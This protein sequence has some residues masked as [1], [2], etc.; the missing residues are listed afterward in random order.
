MPAAVVNERA[1]AVSRQLYPQF[2][3]GYPS[4]SF[5]FLK[6]L[7]KKPRPVQQHV[8]QARLPLRIVIVGA[9]LG[10]LAT[11]IALARRGH[12]VEVLEQASQLGE[13]GAGIQVPPNSCLLLQRWGVLEHL[14][15]HAVRPESI[16]FRKW[17]NGETV[18]Y[19][20]LRDMEHDFGAAYLVCHRADLH[21][22]LLAT[23]ANLGVEIRLD[24]KVTKY[25]ALDGSVQLSNGSRIAGDLIVGADGIHSH[26]RAAVLPEM[27]PE[28]KTTEFAAYRATIEVSKMRAD[29]E[30]SWLLE[31]PSLNIWIGDGSHV[32]AYTI[33]RG[34]AFNMVL[35]H[36]DQSDPATWAQDTAVDD[37]KKHFAS[38]DPQLVKLTSM[39]D[40]CLKWP[41]KTGARL[42]TWIHPSSK[43]LI[44]GD[45]AHAMLP[46]MS[47]GAA[48]AVENGAA[49]AVALNDVADPSEIPAALQSFEAERMER[50]TAMQE[51]SRANGIIWHYEDGPEQIARDQGMRA[52]VEG[53]PFSWSSNQWSDPV[54]SWWTYGYDAE[55]RMA[56]AMRAVKPPRRN[57]TA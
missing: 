37:M 17:S 47:Q 18:G 42:R 9:G 30:L 5:L 20:E 13:V 50:S 48:M 2:D 6:D 11:A 44:L 38:W 26:A 53:R 43:M 32:M 31:K 12:S 7:S 56:R 46:Y 21:R 54:T 22:S 25:D 1:Q 23:A 52:E 24:S 45:A 33:S 55:E 27:G 28:P 14:G 19:T 36:A 35:C 40:S 16:K 51:A 8:T 29:P 34:E 10:G 3:V 49:L 39:I 15:P 4:Q 57:V 41:L